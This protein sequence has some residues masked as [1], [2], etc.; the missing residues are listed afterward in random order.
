MSTDTRHITPVGFVGVTL[1]M[2]IMWMAM[3]G[4]YGSI[5]LA[6]TYLAGG[7]YLLFALIGLGSFGIAQSQD[8]IKRSEYYGTPDD[9]SRLYVYLGVLVNVVYINAYLIAASIIGAVAF[10]LAGTEIGYAAAAGAISAYA[11]WETETR[12]RGLPASIGGVLVL[13]IALGYIAIK[14][15]AT[16]QNFLRDHDFRALFQSIEGVRDQVLNIL[17]RSEGA[18]IYKTARRIQP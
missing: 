12:A 1:L 16:I 9:V 4:I 17:G 3:A 13:A 18:P 6:V 15:G 10:E 8:I 7:S 5:A 2:T 11:F 14:G